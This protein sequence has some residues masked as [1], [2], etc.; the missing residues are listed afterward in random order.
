MMGVAKNFHNL[1]V[2]LPNKDAST[3]INNV[4]SEEMKTQVM[5]KI[6]M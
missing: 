3:I 1:D 6:G 4:F 2:P 5:A